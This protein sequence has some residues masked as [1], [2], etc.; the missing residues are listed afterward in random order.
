MLN[1]PEF[2][3]YYQY[4]IQQNKLTNLTAITDKEDVYIKHFYDSLV[5]TTQI[6]FD[7]KKVLD[8][9][10]GAGFPSIPIH[11]IHESMDLTIVDGLN[12]RIHFLENLTEKLDL[13]V[14]LIHGRAENL[15]LSKHFDIILARAVAKLNIL[16][17]MALPLL[18]VN[19][20]FV[21][22]KSIHYQEELQQA[23][24]AI[25]V[26]GGKVEEI[27]EY[28]LTD[29]LKHVYIIIKKVKDTP[30]MYPR[31]FSKIKKLPL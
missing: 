5:I 14:S 12:K 13:N 17:E 16:L 25:Q 29:D 7:Q 10:A 6:D 18:K 8:I 21:A 22:Y 4:L 9:G 24:N 31:H 1:K 20:Y 3:T 15:D 23:K 11:L 2:L 28:T 26:L 30:K 19:G 27:I